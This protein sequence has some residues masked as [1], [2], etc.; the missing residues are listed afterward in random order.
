ME[1]FV[2]EKIYYQNSL[3]TPASVYMLS[4][5]HSQQTIEQRQQTLGQQSHKCKEIK[6][7]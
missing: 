2:F 6:Q 3:K 7:Y 4:F 1:V 5:K